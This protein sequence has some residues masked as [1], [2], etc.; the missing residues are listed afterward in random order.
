MLKREKKKK[1]SST[2][3]LKHMYIVQHKV[4]FH[5]IVSTYSPLCYVSLN[6]NYFILLYQ[7]VFFACDELLPMKQTLPV[8]DSNYRSQKALYI[9]LSVSS[10]HCMIY[11]RSK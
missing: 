1:V 6:I 7:N 9:F 2:N 8:Y 5:N 10:V 4:Y 3:T 11:R